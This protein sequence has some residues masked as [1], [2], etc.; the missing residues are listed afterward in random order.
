M[1]MEGTV[2][3]AYFGTHLVLVEVGVRRKKIVYI[4]EEVGTHNA[5]PNCMH[6]KRSLFLQ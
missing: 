5:F 3:F 6:L 2:V 1:G 4:S